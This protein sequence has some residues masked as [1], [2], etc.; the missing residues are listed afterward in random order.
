LFSCISRCLSSFLT[1]LF[2]TTGE[3]EVD[4]ST[5]RS[6]SK[7]GRN[8][9]FSPNIAWPGPMTKDEQ[10]RI[11]EGKEK[12][13]P[14]TAPPAREEPLAV[15]LCVSLPLCITLSHYFLSPCTQL[16]PGSSVHAGVCIYIYIYIHINR[17]LYLQDGS[18]Q[19]NCLISNMPVP[20]QLRLAA[21]EVD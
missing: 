7:L 12:A 9:L 3:W 20:L 15:M 19:A 16:P 18:R 2:S 14:S 13:M 6:Y 1:T 5:S 21:P 10:I 17:H 8:E 11:R 4:G